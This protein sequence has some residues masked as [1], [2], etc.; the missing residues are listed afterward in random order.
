MDLMNRVFK[1][2]L[3]K[4]DLVFIKDILNYLKDKDKHI[5]HLR[6]VLQTLREHHLHSKCKK[7]EFWLKEMIFLGHVVTK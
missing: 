4:F 2:Y 1:P 3:D 7:R 5:I 6:M